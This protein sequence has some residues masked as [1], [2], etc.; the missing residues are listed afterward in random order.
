MGAWGRVFETPARGPDGRRFADSAPATQTDS[1]PLPSDHPSSA[2]PANRANAVFAHGGD[3]NGVRTRYGLGDAPLLDFSASVNPLGPPAE[4]IEAAREAMAK[5][6]R[7]PEPG[8]PRLTERLAAY[9][10]IP[11]DRVIVGAGTTELI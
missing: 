5:V 3:A 4:A 7:Y 6:D 9:H 10:G 1:I 2:A 8:S 11:A